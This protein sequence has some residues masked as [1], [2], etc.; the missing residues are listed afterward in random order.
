M[1]KSPL[2]TAAHFY[3]YSDIYN[4]MK[5]TSAIK[6]SI[7]FVYICTINTMG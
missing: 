1:T 6:Q 3:I 2:V 7:D 4:F 5:R